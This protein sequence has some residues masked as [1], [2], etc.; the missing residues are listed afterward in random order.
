M[1]LTLDTTK[2]P[3][4][5]LSVTDTTTLLETDIRDG[6]ASDSVVERLATFGKNTFEEAR[7]AP[8]V[9]IFIRQFGSPLILVLIA[10]AAVTLFIGHYRDALFI[11]TAVIANTLLGF[12]QE[13]KAEQALAELKTYLKQRARVIRD[14]IERDS[15]AD[16]LV[17]GDVI[18]LTQGDRVPADAR[19]VSANDVQI[20]EAV[21]TGESLPVAKSTE[22]VSDKNAPVSERS[23]MVFAGTLVTQGVATAIVCGTGTGTEIGKIAE[24]VAAAEREETP[25]Q[26]AI[27]R[28]S[29][30]ASVFLVGLTVAIFFIGLAFGQ[31]ALDMFLTSVAIAVS[32]IP[33]GLPVAMT[34]ILAVGVERMARRKGVVRK[35]VAA[36][37]LGG[38]TVIL[39]DKTGTLTMAKME[40]AKVL[41]EHDL[42]ERT[43]LSRA[44]ANISVVIENPADAPDVWR[45]SG[46]VLETSL[47]RAAAIR[48]VDMRDVRQTLEPISSLPFNAVNKFSATF[49]RESE[50]KHT[51]LFFG[52]PDILV[53][54]STLADAE[55]EAVL[56][57]IEVLARGGE[58]VLGVAS[59]A[60]GARKE[61]SFETEPL[62]GLSFDGLITFRDPVRPGVR[63]VVARL[64]R[65]GIR[66][67]IVTGDHRGTAEAV[68]KE[69][70]IEPGEDGVIDAESLGR[71]NDE[72]LA[73]RLSKLRVIARVTPTDKV[74]IAKAFQKSGDVVAMTGDGVNDAPSIKQADVGIAMG[75]GTEVSR[76][77]A[78]LVLLDDNFMTIAAAV[79][80]G[81]QIL[82]NIKKTI[83]YLL[84]SVA[85]ELLLIGGALVTGIPLPLSALQILWVNF[86]SDSFPAVAFAFEKGIDGLSRRSNTASRELFDPVMRFLIIAIGLSTSLFLFVLYW[87][88]LRAGIDVELVRTFIFA[89]FGTYTLFLPFSLR[90]LEKSI[91]EYKPFSNVYMVAGAGIGIVMMGLAVYAP[92]LHPVLGT[93]TL[94]FSWLIGVAAVGFLNIF[95]VELGKRVFRAR[96]MM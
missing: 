85:D 67:V 76:S 13:R 3:F 87:F 44:L 9:R 90:S 79:D 36:E 38:T 24:L 82:A 83:V 1:A 52:A 54:R 45:M 27:K 72:E 4:W 64:E 53:A 74:R 11:M 49:V 33:E 95:A 59:K 78:D 40:L 35:L 8:G 30:R 28:F 89:C 16:T 51:L 32:A 96:R 55:R 63:D 61:F 43:L 84:S 68:A 23:S 25:L 5:H 93:T 86:F 56:E 34:V 60:L 65:S 15:D 94:P 12:Y 18:R 92:F 77:V 47:V 20:D 70:G 48:G 58:R 42:D 17:P 6:L 7:R 66:T 37:T 46:R 26:H 80:E 14:G 41:P 22:S 75:S 91:L 81:R 69:V 2:R 21:L 31:S 71:L 19:I 29:L 10:A 39:T 62:D 88:L 50:R 73:A 57:R